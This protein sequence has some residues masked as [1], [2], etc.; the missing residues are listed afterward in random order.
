[1]TKST[2]TFYLFHGDDDLRMDEEVTRMRAKMGDGPNGDLNTSDFD[3]TSTDV[4]EILGAATSYPF[5][6]DKRLVIVKDLIAHITRKG[7]GSTGKKAVELLLETL[8]GLPDWSRL[9]LVERQKLSDSNKVLQLA[10]KN[11]NGIEKAF[12][13][14]KDSTAWI[15]KRAQ[16]EYQAE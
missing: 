12:V 13:A 11:P 5:L 7:A 1:M 3:G 2:P 8:P 10:Q 4:G 14:P 9:V 6:A 16:D 15:V